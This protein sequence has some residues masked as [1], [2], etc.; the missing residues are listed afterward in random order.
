MQVLKQ[1]IVTGVYPVGARLPTEAELCSRFRVSRYTVREALRQMRTDGLVVSRRGAGTTV[2]RSGAPARYVHTVG[3]IEELVSYATETRYEVE[4]SNR[5]VSDGVLA[6]RLGCGEGE[7]WLRI[8]G[9][10]YAPG[11]ST[12]IC[13]TE[14][15]VRS[16]FSGITRVLTRRKGPIYAWI[17]DLYGERIAEIEQVLR[18]RPIPAAVAGRLEVEPQSAGIEIRRTYRLTSGQTAEVAFSLHPADRFTYSMTLR[19]GSP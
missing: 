13:W 9:L 17:E 14:V 16:E 12:P 8:D 6:E 10:R 1:E 15:F 18:A 3:S 11:A 19:R 7:S 4:H 5:V 2:A